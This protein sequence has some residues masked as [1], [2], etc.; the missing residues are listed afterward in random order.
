MPSNSSTS[1]IISGSVLSMLRPLGN[2]VGYDPLLAENIICSR[3]W[4]AA[5]TGFWVMSILCL[6]LD[7]FKALRKWKIQ[8]ARSYFTMQEWCEAAFIACVNLTLSSWSVAVPFNT[9]WHGGI[10]YPSSSAMQ[11]DSPW[12]W[13]REL[14]CLLGCY[15]VV[16]VCFYSTHRLLHCGKVYIA[17]HKMHHRFTAPTSVA[18]VYAH[19]IEFIFGNLAGVMLGPI[20]TNAHPYT[21][22]FNNNHPYIAYDLSTSIQL[23]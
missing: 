15:L 11:E 22:N 21:G 14:L 7:Q 1:F 2:A 18:A 17:I 13:N 3:C 6:V 10:F 19:P 12:N 9:L 16:D 23:L 5:N 4:I 20:L 8:G